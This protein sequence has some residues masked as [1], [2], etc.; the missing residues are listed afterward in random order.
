LFRFNSDFHPVG[1]SPSLYRDGGG[2]LHLAFG[3]GGYVDP[4]STSW[5]PDDTRQFM[6]SVAL[7]PQSV[8]VSESSPAPDLAWSVDLGFGQ[9]VYAQATI[10]GGEL[11]VTSDRTDANDTGYGLESDTGKLTR[12]ALATGAVKDT[13]TIHSGAASADASGG[14]VYTTDEAG[15]S[16]ADYRGDF[17]GA[18]TGT[19]FSITSSTGAK[20]W[21][22]IE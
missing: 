22:R 5:S 19:E 12:I 2:H 4:V 8:P 15:V 16:T 14:K 6:V 20:L 9:R 3:S 7:D 1:A 17:D 11:Y 13:R 21:L 10:A 18:G